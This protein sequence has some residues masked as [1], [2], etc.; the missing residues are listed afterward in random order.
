MTNL[1]LVSAKLAET[2][3]TSRS[4]SVGFLLS[5]LHATDGGASSGRMNS[6]KR[7]V[8]VMDGEGMLE[9]VFLTLRE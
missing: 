2:R 4:Q 6:G 1:A 5:F 7:S 3:D 9:F 8:L